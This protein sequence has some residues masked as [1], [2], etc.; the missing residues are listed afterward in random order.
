MRID[1][2]DI[3]SMTF[4]GMNNVLQA[5]GR[6]IRTDTDR[7]FI[8]FLDE[9]YQSYEYEELMPHEYH[10]RRAGN[11]DTVFEMIKDFL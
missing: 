11:I 2:N 6:V 4:P 10:I 8:V 1:F 3:D 9:R 7:G 5:A